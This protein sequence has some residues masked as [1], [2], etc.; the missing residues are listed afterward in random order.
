MTIDID[1]TTASGAG[2]EHDHAWR[3]VPGSVADERL[4]GEYRCDLCPAVWSL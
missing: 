2:T 3:K 4:V 1:A